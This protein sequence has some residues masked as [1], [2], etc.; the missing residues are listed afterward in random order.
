[1]TKVATLTCVAICL[2]AVSTKAQ[3][4]PRPPVPYSPLLATDKQL[5]GDYTSTVCN[6][7]VRFDPRKL[8][9]IDDSEKIPFSFVPHP[10][11]LSEIE[12]MPGGYYPFAAYLEAGLSVE[13][14]HVV[15]ETHAAYDD[16]HKTD[17]GDQPNPKGHDRHL[18][19]DVFFRLTKL[20]HPKWMLG[21]GYRWSQLSTTNYTKGGSRPQFGAAYDLF[22]DHGGSKPDCGGYCWYSARFYADYFLAGT[23]WQN[24]SHGVEFGM[25]VPRPVENKHLFVVWTLGIFRFHESI[26]ESN[27]PT[28]VHK[29]LSD[30][31]FD[32][33][34]SVGVMYRFNLPRLHTSEYL[35]FRRRALETYYR[36]HLK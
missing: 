3:S 21:G 17:D 13:S 28:L 7:N 33:S 11:L 14:R 26:T 8:D 31:S 22:F 9:N 25:T 20:G 5:C 10:Y 29:Q 1:M 19:G 36:I 16:G 2:A 15:V 4:V 18:Q 24:G 35:L 27:N 23:D 6:P 34:K 30:K 12:A 32:S